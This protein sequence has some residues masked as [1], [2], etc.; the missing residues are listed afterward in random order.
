MSRIDG[1]TI[2]G[3]RSFAPDHREAISLYTPLTLIVGYNGSGKTTIIECLK[4][5]TTGDLPPNSRNGAFVHDP[6][7]CNEKL[8]LA[9]VGLKFTS[10]SGVQ[11]VLHRK[12]Q[13]SVAK[14]GKSTFKTIEASL[15]KSGEAELSTSLK[16][17]SV[18]E[19][20]ARLLGVSPAILDSVIFCHQEESLWPMSEPAA[21]KKKFDEIFEAQSYTKLIDHLKL[22]R[23]QRGERLRFHQQALKEDEENVKRARE[24]TKA[25]EKLTAEID[26]LSEEEAELEAKIESLKEAQRATR[27]EANQFLNILGDLNNLQT[28]LEHKEATVAELRD[29]IEILSDGDEE[30]KRALA[31]SDTRL[32]RLHDLINEDTAQYNRLEEDGKD[33]STKLNAKLGEK[34]RLE[35]DKEKYERQL[36]K[37]IEMIQQAAKKHGIPGFNNDLDDNQVQVFK[38]KIQAMF[39]TKKKEHERLENELAKATN[40][41]GDKISELE[42]KKI[43]LTSART[44]AKQ[45]RAE[46]ERK[47]K[48]LQTESD[49][50]DCD[51]GQINILERNKSALEERYRNAQNDFSQSAWDD[52]IQGAKNEVTELESKSAELS[53]ELVACTTLSSERAQLDLRKKELKDREGNLQSLVGTYSDRISKILRCEFNIDSIGSDYKSKFD[54]ETALVKDEKDQCDVLQGELNQRE[55]ELAEARRRHTTSLDTKAKY[56][57]S[58]LKVLKQVVEPQVVETVSV[59]DFDTQFEEIED[60]RSV[61]EKD[62]NLFDKMKDYYTQSQTYLHTKNRCMLCER[63]FDDDQ[64]KSKLL[65]KIAKGLDDE[66]KKSIEAEYRAADAKFRQLTAVRADYDALRRLES[67]LSK[68]KKDVEEAQRKREDKLHQLEAAEGKRAKAEDALSEVVSVSKSVSEITQ[69]RTDIEESK[70]QIGRLQ[71]QSQ[72]SGSGRSADEIHTA[73]GTISDK[74]KEARKSLENLTRE[75][76]R[77]LD[78]VNNLELERSENR[79]KLTQAKQQMDKKATLSRDIKALKDENQDLEK[80]LVNTDQE[81]KAL[82]PQIDSA[83]GQRDAAREAGREKARLVAEARDA[84]ASTVSSLNMVEADIQDYED[85]G[86]ASLLTSCERAIHGLQQQ[87]DRLKKDMADMMERINTQKKEHAQGDGRK[88]NINDNLRYR[89]YCQA[90]DNLTEKIEQLRTHNAED[91]YNRLMGEVKRLELEEV[92]LTGRKNTIV[93]QMGAKDENM[94]ERMKTHD[95]FYQ[96]AEAKYKE[97]K[98]KME[99]NKAAIEDI[100]TTSNAVDKAVMQFHSLKMEEINRIV[101]ELW[102]S[103]YMG[104]DIDTIAIRSENDAP[105]ATASTARKQYNYRVTMVKQDTEMDMR[106]RCSA[107]QKVLASIIIRLALAQSFGI[108]CGLIALDEPTTNL[109]SDNIK[110]LA[111]SLHGIIQARQAQA[112]FQL[113]VITHDEEFLR[114][115]RCNEFCDFFYRVTRNRDQKSAI[116]K[117]DISRIMD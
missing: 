100:G 61:A 85:R 57:Q 1:L 29:S 69:L 16:E 81:L 80:A 58:V 89:Q 3:I 35:S 91:D 7:L 117:E 51:E 111:V 68:M 21:L 46:N 112:N 104:T 71:S 10:L 76:Q 43:S 67:D 53:S 73:Q 14:S 38:E 49:S 13:V 82:Q 106:G 31:Q 9:D 87:Y 93:G 50:V 41:A 64:L 70:V 97:T 90:V 98:I 108:N 11:H 83:R 37:R 24:N 32:A 101:G 60:I 116:S 19:D 96:G 48:R 115:M 88:R 22:I 84:I 114:Y 17:R 6:K 26:Q 30:L 79:N 95:T 4:Y 27:V 65:K 45:R 28:E 63:G 94:K 42:T 75:R 113:I 33:I 47:I 62:L 72:M 2:Q 77:L 107:G 18:D 59:E 8:I 86:K 103:T 40:E 15:K 5:A 78:L 44:S 74:L 102:R 12:L 39:N 109:D 55:F 52:K 56:E 92:R 66:Q 110:S 23:K 25:I 105:S 20:L 34:G 54:E 36:Q 99:T